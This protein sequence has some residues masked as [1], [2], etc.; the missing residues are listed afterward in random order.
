MTDTLMFWVRT[1]DLIMLSLGL[2]STSRP[3]AFPRRR[4]ARQLTSPYTATSW[5]LSLL[6]EISRR[7]KS[8]D[9][10]LPPNWSMKRPP[11][12]CQVLSPQAA[13]ARER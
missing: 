3:R 2:V 10:Y 4:R 13:R 7:E 8:W 12:N 1:A 11:M 5:R 9:L 6:K